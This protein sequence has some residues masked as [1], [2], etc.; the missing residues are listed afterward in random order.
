MLMCAGRNDVSNG[1]G[2]PAIAD[3]LFDQLAQLVESIKIGLDAYTQEHPRYIQ[4][5]P[6]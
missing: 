1:A 2:Q 5:W 6:N 4:L 3:A